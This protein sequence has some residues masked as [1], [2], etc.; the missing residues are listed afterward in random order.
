MFITWAYNA[1]ANS[2]KNHI[3]FK[4]YKWYRNQ[5]VWNA[6][7]ILFLFQIKIQ[8]AIVLQKSRGNLRERPHDK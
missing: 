3:N 7:W 4:P 5:Y 2:K 6:P 1:I 8:W